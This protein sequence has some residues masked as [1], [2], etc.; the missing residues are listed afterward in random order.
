MLHSLLLCVGLELP[1]D[2]GVFVYRKV[3]V[4]VALVIVQ[5]NGQAVFL[6]LLPQSSS[7]TMMLG[8]EVS[9]C[10]LLADE[11]SLGVLL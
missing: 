10:S 2:L 3:A 5:I 9:V 4:D 6:R 8:K 1:I 11:A 7:E